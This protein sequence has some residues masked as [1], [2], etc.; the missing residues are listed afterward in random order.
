MVTTEG[1]RQPGG[2]TK[3]GPS[4]RSGAGRVARAA[5]RCSHATRPTPDPVGH[6]GAR[7]SR[8]RPASISSGRFKW[9]VSVHSGLARLRARTLSS[10]YLP[11]PDRS[12]PARSSIRRST[13]MCGG[14]IAPPRSSGGPLLGAGRSGSDETREEGSCFFECVSGFF[15]IPVLRLEAREGEPG[16]PIGGLPLGCLAG[17][18]HGFGNFP[19]ALEDGGLLQPGGR[20]ERLDRHG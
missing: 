8:P 5:L 6:R 16:P 10:A 2:E 4:Q 7:T 11:T 13:A 17:G 18:L 15:R 12:I 9:T 14:F 1:P 19:E 3:A 20:R